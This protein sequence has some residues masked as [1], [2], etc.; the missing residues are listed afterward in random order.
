MF[1]D[2]KNNILY[3]RALYKEEKETM[4]LYEYS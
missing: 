4:S 1:Y 3:I 2:D